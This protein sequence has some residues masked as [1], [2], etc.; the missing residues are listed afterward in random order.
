M[1]EAAGMT[2]LWASWLVACTDICCSKYRRVTLPQHADSGHLRRRFHMLVP[3][4]HP[5]TQSWDCLESVIF[6]WTWLCWL[7]GTVILANL[8]VFAC[9]WVQNF[10]SCI[11]SFTWSTYYPELSCFMFPGIPVPLAI[12]VLLTE[13]LQS[14]ILL[15]SFSVCT[16][17]PLPL[18]VR[19]AA[20][21]CLAVTLSLWLAFP[22]AAGNDSCSWTSVF[23]EHSTQTVTSNLNWSSS[24]NICEQKFIVSNENP[25]RIREE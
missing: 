5:R 7:T 8:S 19:W 17:G 1:S 22:C 10:P 4:C 11:L 14:M 12:T 16:V 15:F 18:L 20:P 23:R 21:V 25:N 24:H 9:V 13:W 3:T 2:S 6:P